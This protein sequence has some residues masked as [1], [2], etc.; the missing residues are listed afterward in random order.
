M[1]TTKLANLSKE[2]LAELLS[3]KRKEICRIEQE[4]LR[5]IE[6]E[7]QGREQE[8]AKEQEK[9]QEKGEE[10]SKGKS[11]AKPGAGEKE[12]K[13]ENAPNKSNTS[14][15]NKNGYG[16]KGA[17]KRRATNTTSG[18]RPSGA[19]LFAQ[20][21][22][23]LTSRSWPKRS[24]NSRVNQPD[25]A[26]ICAL[27]IPSIGRLFDVIMTD[28][29][30]QLATSNPTRGVAIG[31]QQLADSLIRAIPFGSLQDNGFLFHLGDQRQ[32]QVCS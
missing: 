3:A 19:S 28:P 26:Q 10:S 22:G 31:Y 16:G 8:E 17:K 30:W 9:A 14:E 27:L 21:F 24:G 11:A 4:L 12:K 32:I 7:F 1:A 18:K 25:I 29:P 20:M 15:E 23:T 13:D 5:E 6:T 2:E